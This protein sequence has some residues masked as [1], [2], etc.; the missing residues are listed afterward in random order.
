MSDKKA[1]FDDVQINDGALEEIGKQI[2]ERLK[3]VR[4][5]EERAAEKAGVEL[6]QAQNHRDSIAQLLAEAKQQCSGLGFKVFKEKY[7]PDLG[8]SRIYELLAIG[9]GRKTAEEVRSATRERT[10][11]A[12]ADKESATGDVAD[13]S[14][15]LGTGQALSVDSLG[16]RAKEQ[17]TAAL[18][19]AEASAEQRKALYAGAQ[20]VNEVLGLNDEEP[21][22]SIIPTSPPASEPQNALAEFEKACDQWLPLMT[23]DERKAARVY[24]MQWKE[25]RQ[26]KAKAA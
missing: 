6:K 10:A 25:R 14:V 22:L 18:N 17:I 16:D 3:K 4:Q 13:T 23:E 2:A 9:E 7:C 1:K 5:Y 19:E 20:I 21:H 26:R 8:K 24:H 15:S 11:K 12:R